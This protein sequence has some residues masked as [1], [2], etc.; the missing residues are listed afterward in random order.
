MYKSIE[1]VKA[2]MRELEAIRA[3]LHPAENRHFE[4]SAHIDELRRLARMFEP[5]LPPICHSVIDEM[6]S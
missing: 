1:D 3:T 4:L 2:D 6:L 5:D